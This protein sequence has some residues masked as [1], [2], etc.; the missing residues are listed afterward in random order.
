MAGG[1][2]GKRLRP[3]EMCV[4]F[5]RYWRLRKAPGATRVKPLSTRLPNNARPHAAATTGREDRRVPAIRPLREAPRGIPRGGD[6]RVPPRHCLRA[7]RHC[8]RPTAGARRGRRLRR[9]WSLR[10]HRHRGALAKTQPVGRSQSRLVG[11]LCG[12]GGRLDVAACRNPRHRTEGDRGDRPRD[13]E[14]DRRGLPAPARSV[15]CSAA[16]PCRSPASHSTS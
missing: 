8:P 12:A 15:H 10:R 5:V 16:G 6:R 7:V 11:G 9:V 2:S 13:V 3:P 14:L 1:P 4:T